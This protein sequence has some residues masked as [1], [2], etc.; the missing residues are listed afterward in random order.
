VFLLVERTS[1]LFSSF[2]AVTKLVSYRFARICDER[3]AEL[4]SQSKS[5]LS[6][7]LIK[8]NVHRDYVRFSF[9]NKNEN[10]SK[11]ISHDS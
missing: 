7:Q 4:D 9:Q 2:D 5:S 1:M 6:L 10:D 3:R 11:N 8:M